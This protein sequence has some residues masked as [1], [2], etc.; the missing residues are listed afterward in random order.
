MRDLF[1][2]CLLDE[3]GQG[4]GVVVAIDG[5]HVPGVFEGPDEMCPKGFVFLDGVAQPILANRF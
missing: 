2:S 3:I 1:R 5:Q 4:V